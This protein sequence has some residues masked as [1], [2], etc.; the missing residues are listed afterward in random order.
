MRYFM[1]D[2]VVEFAPG[3][4]A[5]GVKCV[6]LTD[7]TLHDHFPDHPVLPGALILEACAQLGGF[8]LEESPA[9]SD[10]G[11]RRALLVQ[12]DKAKFHETCGPGDRLEIEATLGAIREDAAQVDAE[13]SVEGRR[14]ARAQLTFMMK[15]IPSR[16]LRAQRRYLYHLWTKNLKPRS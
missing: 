1:I 11:A 9:V 10:G 14:V 7:E 12:I 13:V 2:R 5:R 4:F 16:R 15:E 6:T 3:E 8:L